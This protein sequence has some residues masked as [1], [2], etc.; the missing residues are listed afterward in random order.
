MR[1]QRELRVPRNPDS[2]PVVVRD[3]G[4]KRDLRVRFVGGWEEVEEPALSGDDVG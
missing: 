3:D 4:S 1:S 2:E